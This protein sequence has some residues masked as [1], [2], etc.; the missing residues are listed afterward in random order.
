M[1][2]VLRITSLSVAMAAI[3]LPAIGQGIAGQWS[4]QVMDASGNEPRNVYSLT[5]AGDETPQISAYTFIFNKGSKINELP[6][7]LDPVELSSLGSGCYIASVPDVMGSELDG[8][9]IEADIVLCV[10]DSRLY[11]M[12]LG[13]QSSYIPQFASF[14][15]D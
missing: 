8:E 5:I 6:E 9:Q 1:L 13:D 15:R 14:D 3:A 7:G 2:E 11:W 12:Q 10:R 4:A